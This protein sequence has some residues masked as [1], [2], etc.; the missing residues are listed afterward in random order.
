[1]KKTLLKLTALITML[2]AF[3]SCDTLLN[4][5]HTK[6]GEKDNTKNEQTESEKDS[7]DSEKDPIESGDST[8]TNGIADLADKSF[9]YYED[10]F[11]SQYIY[12][13][14]AATVVF[15][16]KDSSKKW[17]TEECTINETGRFYSKILEHSITVKVIDGKIIFYKNVINAKGIDENAN[18]KEDGS[19]GLLG[20]WVYSGYLNPFK[21]TITQNTISLNDVVTKSYTFKNGILY[22]DGKVGFYY[23]GKNLYTE[24]VQEADEISDTTLITEIKK[25]ADC[26]DKDDESGNE[27]EDSDL[28]YKVLPAGTD[29]T[30][31]TDVTYVTFGEWP[32]TLKEKSVTIDEKDFTIV[33]AFT[34]YKG[35]DDAWY[36]KVSKDYYKVEPIK[37]RL[38]TENYGGKKLLLA[39]QILINCAFYDYIDEERTIEGN[40]IY[41]N[42]YKESRVRAYLNGLSYYKKELFYQ[43]ETT[44]SSFVGKGFLQ[45]AF[46]ASE[47]EQIATTLVD[48]SLESTT[49]D[50]YDEEDKWNN[51][52]CENTNDK[53]FLLSVQEVTREAY[54]FNKESSEDKVRIRLP[55]DFAEANGAGDI[56]WL[57]SPTNYSSENAHYI[58]SEGQEINNRVKYKDYGVVPALCL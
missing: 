35:S 45:T 7:S 54:K 52:I 11:Q 50:S 58:Y 55:T 14:D 22:V 48:N 44:D 13:K 17:N 24:G 26:K 42:N 51:Y 43:S 28:L 40:K 29:G 5:L 10:S 57:R 20:T 32:Q 15:C 21:Y 27:T 34:Y 37:W 12:F 30:A 6:D 47:Q 1:M 23:D 56:W 9:L 16:S 49:P 41:S 46:S 18:V 3:S 38:L 25:Y 31:G 36:A 4:S 39:D 33:G 53:I 2:C 8:S 19:E